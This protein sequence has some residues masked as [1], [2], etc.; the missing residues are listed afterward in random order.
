MEEKSD[1]EAV[2]G[3]STLILSEV[4]YEEWSNE[5]GAEIDADCLGLGAASLRTSKSDFLRVALC[6]GFWNRNSCSTIVEFHVLTF[7]YNAL[8]MR[9]KVLYLFFPM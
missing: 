8:C 5:G 1:S 3:T 9:Q 6:S 7:A 2:T 4:G